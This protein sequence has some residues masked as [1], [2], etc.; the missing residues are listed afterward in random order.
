MLN[1]IN[2]RKGFVAGTVSGLF[3]GIFLKVVE[4]VTNLKVYTL[5]LNVDYVPILN[6]Y[7]LHES[8]EFGIHLIISIFLS[9]F[10]TLFLTK[11]TWNSTTKFSFV[12]F[13]ST[14]IGVLLYPTT[15][16]SSRTPDITNF[17]A[18]SFWMI[19][20]VLYGLILAV[21]LRNSVNN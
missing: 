21:L 5:L 19:G 13:I 14:V 7:S 12:W 2:I 1:R 4:V 6:Q 16:L 10:L 9:L 18:L 15:S 20:H 8:I 3:L 11:K 17:A